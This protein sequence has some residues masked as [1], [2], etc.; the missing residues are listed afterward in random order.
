V[1][2]ALALLALLSAAAGCAA[3]PPVPG[4]DPAT[5]E[6]RAAEQRLLQDEAALARAA[7]QDRPP[8]CAHARLLR[9]NICAL[10]ERICALAPRSTDPQAGARCQDAR[11]R[12]QRARARVAGRCP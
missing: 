7:A 1:T 4:A 5:R 10:A 12:C 6:L 9:D 8:D 11:A 2:R 3:A